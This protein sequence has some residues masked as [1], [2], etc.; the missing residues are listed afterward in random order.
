M[1][2]FKVY[3][4]ETLNTWA[5]SENYQL[6][7]EKTIEKE[8]A[9][10]NH[11][12]TELREKRTDLE[13]QIEQETLTKG[14]LY[15]KGKTLEAAVIEALQTLGFEAGGYR[16]EES[17]F[18]IIF[19][20][21]EGRFLGEAE[22]KDSSAINI[23]KLQQLERNIQE[24]FAKEHGTDYAK[25]VLFGNPH[26]LTEPRKR[27]TL[28]TAKALSAARRSGFAL[29]HTADLFPIVQY[30]KNTKNASFARKVRQCFA[31]TS[32]EIINFP[33]IPV[34]A[35]KKSTKPKIL[36]DKK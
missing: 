12:I 18:D 13:K 24:D 36:D 26:R 31:A 6:Q 19:E 22:G 1:F 4:Q 16:D 29:V 30:L 7:I 15:E 32:G 8:I 23:E 3:R 2:Y 17:E 21:D 10:I 27:T 5:T 11:K 14:L 35:K 34:K 28:F 33:S 9:Q 20:S 25:G